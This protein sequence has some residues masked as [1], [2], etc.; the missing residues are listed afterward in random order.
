MFQN[1]FYLKNADITAK[2]KAKSDFNIALM[3]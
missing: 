1:T 3:F 2:L